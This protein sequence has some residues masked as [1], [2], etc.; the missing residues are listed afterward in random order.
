MTAYSLQSR[1]KGS[2]ITVSSL[3]PGVV[4]ALT[5]FTLVS[6][7]VYMSHGGISSCMHYN[8]L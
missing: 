3:H 2:G 7:E 8:W 4:R 6:V 5:V 1:L